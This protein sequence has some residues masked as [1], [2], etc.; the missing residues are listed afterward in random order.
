M[1]HKYNIEWSL[2]PGFYLELLPTPFFLICLQIPSVVAQQASS[3][4]FPLAM[5]LV[6]CFC[7][8][9]FTSCGQS[10]TLLLSHLVY[11]AQPLVQT[12]VDPTI[13]SLQPTLSLSIAR[14]SFIVVILDYLDAIISLS[15]SS[16]YFPP[17]ITFHHLKVT[18]YNLR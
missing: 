3:L 12:F 17:N 18:I 1:H 15:A 10:P 9:P 11:L 5:F 6:F 16:A 8:R 14:R 2:F 13:I 4:S 7:Q